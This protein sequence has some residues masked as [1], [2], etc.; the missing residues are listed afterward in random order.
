MKQRLLTILLSMIMLF[1]TPIYAKEDQKDTIPGRAIFVMAPDYPIQI[2]TKA[3]TCQNKVINI[4]VKVPQIKGFKNTQFEKQ[5]NKSFLK[6]AV[7]RKKQLTAEAKINDKH[8]K[9]LGY[10]TKTYELIRNFTIKQTIDPYV[11][12][13][14]FEYTY[15]GGAHGLSD[16]KYIV[17]NKDTSEI[18]TLKD[19][20]E[21]NTPYQKT[22]SEEIKK[23]IPKK[24]A[25]GIMFFDDI[26]AFESIADD[27]T[28]YIDQE[29]NLV[30][31]F[32]VYEIA[33][34]VSGIIEF[35]IPKE[36]IKNSLLLQK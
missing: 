20:F 18:I 4:N 11:V 36:N 26:G 3:I 29:G 14:I 31:V 19:L 8:A 1:S 21:K 25:E 9:T 2:G 10:P 35:T 30:V 7:A 34:Y 12:I 22:I 24:K 32:N 27:Q 13:G 28:F 15:T 17:I 5:L 6:E 16:Q 33:P 23:Q